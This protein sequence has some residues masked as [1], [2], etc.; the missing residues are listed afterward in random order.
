MTQ[1]IITFILVLIVIGGIAWYFNR[2]Y[3]H[4]EN[5]EGQGLLPSSSS[6]GSGV[7]IEANLFYVSSGAAH[8]IWR[9]E[10]DKKTKKIFT[11]ADE[12]EKISKFS[13]IAPDTKEVVAVTVSNKL[14]GINLDNPK[15]V[16]LQ[17][18]F[19][20]PERLSLSPNGQK[21][22]YTRFSNVEE[23][24]GYT[25]YVE[26]KNGQKRRTL[27]NRESEINSLV[28]GPSGEQIAYAAITGTKAEIIIIEVASGDKKSIAKESD[29][30][31]DTISWENDQIFFSLR[32]LS[33]ESGEIYKIV[34]DGKNQEKIL[35][36]EG[37][38]AN[39]LSAAND[40]I[41]Y[42]VAQYKGKLNDTTSGQIYIADLSGQKIEPLKKSIQ[43]LGWLP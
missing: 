29:K 11:D 24:Y 17:E 18:T 23:D 28:W 38:V 12:R 1:K 8:E 39:F 5:S 22:G 15:L 10:P 9:I 34:S 36:F 33:A 41:A 14:V 27:E 25:L 6:S 43:I 26:E 4:E 13:N 7:G 21:I 35:S 30:I 20:S 3:I 31:I 32:G 16:V 42:L 2:T 40:K 37:G 19:G